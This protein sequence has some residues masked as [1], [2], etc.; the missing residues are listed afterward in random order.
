MRQPAGIETVDKHSHSELVHGN[1]LQ[2]P[3]LLDSLDLLRLSPAHASRSVR[4]TKSCR[5]TKSRSLDRC[6]SESL[7]S[8]LP[9][10]GSARACTIHPQFNRLDLAERLISL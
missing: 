6:R 7:N 8:T 9:E 5:I 10:P 4:I 3:D 1:F 2:H